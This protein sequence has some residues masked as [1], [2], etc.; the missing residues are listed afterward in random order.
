[1][2]K[3]ESIGGVDTSGFGMYSSGTGTGAITGGG[4]LPN[5]YATTPTAVQTQL[6]CSPAHSEI[7]ER[8]VAA[9]GAGETTGSDD[10]N[11]EEGETNHAKKGLMERIK[12]KLP[13]H[14]HHHH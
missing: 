3:A 7:K 11:G 8:V 1:M 2:E 4:L 14:H 12:D 13:G 9:S 6:P 10:G 5:Q